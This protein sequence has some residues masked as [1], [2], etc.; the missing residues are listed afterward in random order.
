MGVIVV[1]SNA[2]YGLGLGL[3]VDA[4]HYNQIKDKFYSYRKSNWQ[5]AIVLSV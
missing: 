1:K 3:L 2:V 4:K 5:Y